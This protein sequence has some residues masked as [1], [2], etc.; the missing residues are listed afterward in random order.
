MRANKTFYMKKIILSILAG[1]AFLAARA[2]DWTG[3]VNSDW[4]NPANWSDTPG[5]GDDITVDAANYTGAMAD[6]VI[7]SNS[8]FT[9]AEM[10]VQGGAHLTISAN[11]S[12]S[13]RVEIL[14]AGTMVTITAGTF[15]VNGPGNN[16]RIV[17]GDDAE[18]V[19]SGG[20]FTIGQRLLFE[21][22][23]TGLINGGTITVGETLALV[24]GSAAQPSGL[25]L[26]SGTIT[27][28]G[29]FAFENEAGNFF[30]Y[31]WQNGGTLNINGDLIWLGAETGS[32]IGY[33]RIT[34][35]LT[36]VTGAILNDP[37]STMNM[38][39]ALDG[40][41][42]ELQHQGASVAMLAGD[43]IKIDAGMW[44]DVNSVIWQN[45]GAVTGQ[46]D[47]LYRA[48]NSILTGTGVYSFGSVQIPAGKT[49]NHVTPAVA[50]VNGSFTAI[51]VFSHSTNKLVL[52][53]VSA[54]S[55]QASPA[56]LSLYDLG[57]ANT[58]NEEYDVTINTNVSVSHN[59]D[60]QEGLVLVSF[61]SMLKVASG[62]TITGGSETAFVDGLIEKTG[63]QAVLFPLGKSPDRYR[64][65]AI[66]APS[67][68]STAVTAAY[69]NSAFGILDPVEAPLQTVSSIEY[70]DLAR[71]GSSDLFSVTVEWND[72]SQSGLTDCADISGTVWNGSQWSFLPST[73]SGLCS[74]ENTGSLSTSVDLPVIGP[75]TIGF[76]ENVYQNIVEVC[77]GASVAVGPNVYDET[78]VYTDVFED[79]NG[80]DSTVVTI[81]TVLE[82]LEFTLTD[83][84]ISISAEVPGA[85]SFQWIDCNNG[86]AAVAGATTSQFTPSV[87]GSY[88]LVAY[89]DGCAGDTS[90]CVTI[91][92]L[93][94]E[95]NDIAAMVYP[96]PIVSGEKLTVYAGTSILAIRVQSPDGKQANVTA[97][98]GNG[99][100][101][102]FAEL[103]PG[104]YFIEIL[105]DKG[106]AVK[107]LVVR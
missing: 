14:G 66:S 107:Q 28:N 49:L 80:E 71:T 44:I 73:T 75:F 7:S 12:A 97:K 96:N 35:G 36:K 51:G 88:A 69:M 38:Q 5:N 102:I 48:G 52:N 86:N 74:G 62:A 25:V 42:A 9:P 61:G 58:A 98:I 90:E 2:Q 101:T 17:F 56:G 11:L 45:A 77:P 87:N 37:A 18:L 31:F 59:L 99:E 8:V 20:T 1:C 54:Q 89:R 103:S 53:G 60:L 83:N 47:G 70:W 104:A 55:V 46:P 34:E 3:A 24:D 43:T 33:F 85:M 57:I 79:V 100:A 81:L 26:N 95:E 64:P 68:A 67:S 40:D 29:E 41:A 32:G 105:T 93:S 39:I 19:M 23:G 65:L 78:G 72:A 76:T 13:D 50:S 82:P 84:V 27:T 22:G 15:A 92:Q 16:A 10:L 91:D 30:P 4:N 63:N 6:P 106:I 94:I 21:L